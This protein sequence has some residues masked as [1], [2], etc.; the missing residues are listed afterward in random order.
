MHTQVMAPFAEKLA[1]VSGGK[2]TAR[3]YPAGE[4]GGG[5]QQ[6]YKRAVDGVADIAFGI[7]GCIETLFPRTMPV[8]VPGVVEAVLF[9]YSDKV[10]QTKL[11]LW[12]E[13]RSA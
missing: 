3:I 4:L 9:S 5:P 10:V 13:D 1:E 6:L 11:G 12:R 8:A 7:S 2:L